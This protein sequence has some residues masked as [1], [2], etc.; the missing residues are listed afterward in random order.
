VGLTV[1]AA[2]AVSLPHAG[3]AAQTGGGTV[4]ADSDGWWS[5]TNAGAATPDGAIT[6]PLPRSPLIPAGSLPVSATFGQ[7]QTD[8]AIGITI[9][10]GMQAT[11]LVMTLALVDANGA[12]S[13]PSQAKL[14]ACP[15]TSFWGASDGGKWADRPQA[16]C[17]KAAA[18]GS[19][20]DDGS[21]TFDLTPIAALWSD[22][23][24]AVAPNGVLLTESAGPPATFQIAF[25]G[26]P[27]GVTFDAELTE[28]TSGAGA[29]DVPVASGGSIS[30]G[31]SF[32]TSPT[33]DTSP[34]PAPSVGGS[35]T[36][37][38]STPTA[39]PPRQRAVGQLASNRAAGDL[40]GGL[41]AGLL[42]L[43]PVALLLAV[44]ASRALSPATPRAERVR[45]QGGVGKALAARTARN[46]RRSRRELP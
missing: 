18:E 12:E 24:E 28:E 29:F 39:T 44:L 10:E 2:V 37:T 41:P 17:T 19:R 46:V 36:P 1:C 26:A 4:T 31:G 3:A 38:A 35:A 9:P 8:A 14:Q 20:N 30:T 40:T 34:L 6:P 13:N 11:K 16:D 5:Q 21:W 42:L 27:D 32:D 15:I 25:A 33:F 43:V 23:F 45:R 22:E 7:P